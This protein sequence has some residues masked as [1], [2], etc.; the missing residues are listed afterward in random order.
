[1]HVQQGQSWTHGVSV[2]YATVG[3]FARKGGGF[4]TRAVNVHTKGIGFV[5]HHQMCATHGRQ[6]QRKSW[7]EGG[8]LKSWW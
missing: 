4:A 7:W 5:K 1:M 2:L 8:V 6:C 3:R